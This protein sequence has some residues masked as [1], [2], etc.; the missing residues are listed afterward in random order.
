MS[1][2][3]STEPALNYPVTYNSIQLNEPNLFYID[4]AGTPIWVA[5]NNEQVQMIVDDFNNA[6]AP[7][8][9]PDDALTRLLNPQKET[10]NVQR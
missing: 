8:G 5:L 6:P 1:A 9:E 10:S 2:L 7:P 4:E 3:I